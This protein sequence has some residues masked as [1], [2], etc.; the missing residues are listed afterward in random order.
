M[1]TQDLLDYIAAQTKNGFT[2]TDINQSLI[3]NGWDPTDVDAA[4]AGMTPAPANLVPTAPATMSREEATA[5][6]KKMGK[7][8]ASWTLFSQSLHLLKQDKEVVLF[9]IL[10]AI[11]SM[12]V[13][14][15]VVTSI[16]ASGLVDTSGEETTI[17]NTPVFYTVVFI[18][19]VIGYFVLTYFKVGLTAVV[20]E[21]I[22]GGDIGFKEGLA[23]ANSIGGKIFVWSLLA[24]TVGLVLKIIS[25]RSEHLG[26]LAASLLGAAW[27][28]VTM[29]I[30]PTL[31]LDNV[32]VWQSVKNSGTVFKKTWGE[33]LI[34]NISLGF[35]TYIAVFGIIAVFIALAITVLSLGLGAIALIVL[36]IL[37]VFTLIATS[38]ILTSLSEIFKVALYS[39]A[40]FGVVAEGFSP[41]FIIGAVKEPKKK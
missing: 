6:V 35:V 36:G 40:R 26:K 4:F 16:L 34:L 1:V 10:S 33:T 20:Y 12:I 37:F 23:R 13:G 27:A 32:S 21:R 5:A 8:K 30:A 29:F 39:Y 18:Y 17:T 41:E 2:K 3:N 22:N 31:L 14:V 15:V 24:G 38:I 11:I 9:P 28:I 7:F 19:Y 25:D